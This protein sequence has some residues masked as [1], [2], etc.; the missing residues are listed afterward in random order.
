MKKIVITTMIAALLLLFTGCQKEIPHYRG[1]YF[2][3]MIEDAHVIEL[4]DQNSIP[5]LRG[6]VR[7]VHWQLDRPIDG[8][9]GVKFKENKY[10]KEFIGYILER[11]AMGIIA[12]E[13]VNIATNTGIQSDESVR[14]GG[15]ASVT[16]VDL[17]KKNFLP[18]GDYIFRLKV[19]G[20]N[21]WDRKEIY[22]Q[23]R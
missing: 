11:E 13:D 1:Y 8:N 23:V 20:T 17:L 19:H 12:L 14:I 18:R 4:K 15:A 6:Y 21:N 9:I 3:A 7:E 2:D 16:K 5:A 10:S 22:V